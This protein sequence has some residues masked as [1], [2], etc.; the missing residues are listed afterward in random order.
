MDGRGK[1][2]DKVFKMA[3]K[4]IKKPGWSEFLKRV[5]LQSPTEKKDKKHSCRR[6]KE[7]NCK[8]SIQQIRTLKTHASY[9]EFH[10]FLCFNK[11]C[12]DSSV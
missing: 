9:A 12:D 1:G 11:G 2:D 8:V 10:F 4:N 6:F 5:K 7:S 3:A